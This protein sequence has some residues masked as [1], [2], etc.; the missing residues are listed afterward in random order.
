MLSYL[1]T[2]IQVS[3]RQNYNLTI[4]SATPIGTGAMSTTMRLETNQG[5][6]VPENL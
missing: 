2:A 6:M 5:D 1:A 4:E 3:I